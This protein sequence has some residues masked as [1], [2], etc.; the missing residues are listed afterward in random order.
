[1]S[2]LDRVRAFRRI[3][4]EQGGIAAEAVC[5]QNAC[6]LE[7]ICECPVPARRPQRY[8][9]QELRL[10]SPVL[11]TAHAA[12]AIV[13]RLAPGQELGYLLIHAPWAGDGHYRVDNPA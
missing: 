8:P 9:S 6:R 1:M 12:R 11:E 13:I 10:T 7:S 2:R 4:P 3:P 5:L